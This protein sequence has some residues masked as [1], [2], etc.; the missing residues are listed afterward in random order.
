MPTK[1][2]AIQHLDKD[3]LLHGAAVRITIPA[4][5]AYDLNS[6]QKGIA[7]LVERLGCRPCFSGADC[8]FRIERDYV[9]DPSLKING[10]AGLG[11]GFASNDPMP[12]R[13][14]RVT[15]PRE[16]SYDLNK[17]NEAVAGIVG[18][19]GC[20][21]CCSGFDIEFLHQREFILDA[22]GKIR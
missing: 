20:S 17:V 14:V 21:P 12:A 5:V 6:L 10:A 19:L 2:E 9:I 16:V 13:Q 7:G 3:K 1:T 4:E 18:K 8:F 15:M 22:A 11:K